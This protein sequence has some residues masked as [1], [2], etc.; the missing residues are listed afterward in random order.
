M[1]STA[2]T[3]AD[4]IFNTPGPGRIEDP[5]ITRVQLARAIIGAM[6]SLLLIY[7][8]GADGGWSTVV[9]DG[10]FK[11]F[12]APWLL[13]FTGPVVIAGFIRYAPPEHRPTLR[14]RLRA[15]LKAVGW[16]LGALA[17]FALCGVLIA[18]SGSAGGAGTS[19]ITS[20]VVLALALPT[21]WLGIFLLFASGK[22]A[23]YA[24]NTADVHATLPALL[25]VV[26]VWEL[27]LVS[28]LANGL[29]HGPP[30]AQLAA[31]LGGP[32]SVTGVALWEL[33]RLRE[34][35][36]VRVRP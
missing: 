31:V 13:I 26:L 5:V 24:F 21:L 22:A 35:Y 4:A 12:V 9:D 8:Y 11:L 16:Y 33:R 29:P 18:K 14:S 23:R 20:V 25:T 17:L 34:H 6:A 10:A 2:R 7:T 28:L 1:W 27:M 19:L 15:P 32:L 36:G 30:A 3:R